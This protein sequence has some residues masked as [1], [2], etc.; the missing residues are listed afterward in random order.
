V[1]GHHIIDVIEPGRDGAPA[2]HLILIPRPR[3][4]RVGAAQLDAHLDR[5]R[6]GNPARPT[7]NRDR[8]RE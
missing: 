1:R 2:E 8:L 3:V 6:I 4:T 5:A 7:A